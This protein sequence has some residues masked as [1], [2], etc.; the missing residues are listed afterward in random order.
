MIFRST[1][2]VSG[3]YSI[4][5]DVCPVLWEIAFQGNNDVNLN[6]KDARSLLE[7]YL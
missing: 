1:Q 3:I 6:A 7:M 5:P 4:R 2:V